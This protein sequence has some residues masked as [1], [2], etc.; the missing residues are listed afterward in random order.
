MPVPLTTCKR[1]LTIYLCRKKL[2]TAFHLYKQII[3]VCEST[4]ICRDPKVFEFTVL[5]YNSSHNCFSIV[6]LRSQYKTLNMECLF[7]ALTGNNPG[8]QKRKSKLWFTDFWACGNGTNERQTTSI[9]RSFICAT[10]S[11]LQIDHEDYNCLG[12]ISIHIT[13]NKRQTDELTARKGGLT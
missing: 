11:N 10:C 2:K 3:L 6:I 5:K 12:N 1:R 7:R 9:L 8:M 4:Q 13:I